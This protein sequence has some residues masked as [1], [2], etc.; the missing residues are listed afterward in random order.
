MGP[1]IGGLLGGAGVG[2]VGQIIDGVKG[3][4]GS[5]VEL[6]GVYEQYNVVLK[7]AMGSQAMANQTM[8]MIQDI[9]ATTPFQVNDLTD[10]YVKL[11]NRGIKLTAA[12]ITNLGDVAATLGKPFGQL[13]DAIV[14]VTS[15]KRWQT[16]GIKQELFK[17][18]DGAEKMRLSFRGMTKEVDRTVLGAKEAIKAFGE[19][20]NIAGQMANI[21]ATTAGKLSNLSDAWERVKVNIGANTPAISS[22]LVSFINMNNTI[23][24]YIG[25]PLSSKLEG[26]KSAVNN[27]YE[28][29]TDL[30]NVAD[31]R[32]EAV[33]TLIQKYPDYFGHL[34]LEKSKQEDVTKA[35]DN[36]NKTLQTK[37]DLQRLN[38]QTSLIKKEETEALQR[39]VLFK[40]LV[41]YAKEIKQ[42]Q[43][44]IKLNEKADVNV[45]KAQQN[46]KDAKDK[47]KGIIAEYDAVRSN[48]GFGGSMG[49]G[50]SLNTFNI[51]QL[52]N[53]LQKNYD[54]NNFTY[55]VLSRKTANFEKEVAGKQESLDT[56]ANIDEILRKQQQYITNKEKV[57]FISE[58]EFKFINPLNNTI[59]EKNYSKYQDKVA[60]ILG[61]ANQREA[62][63]GNT[64]LADVSGGK[65]QLELQMQ[66]E[67]QQWKMERDK[68]KNVREQASQDLSTSR[69]IKQINFKVDTI[70]GVNIENNNQPINPAKLGEAVK[71]VLVNTVADISTNKAF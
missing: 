52:I 30:N 46:I 5:I 14:A 62:E 58:E 6:T 23:N 17:G 34:D 9:A 71:T 69:N 67:K 20:V 12:E 65:S 26:E 33:K 55:E 38:E 36:Y 47:A 49:M 1:I 35:L 27:L 60:K 13:N 40:Q 31:V 10:S 59:D 66:Y 39:T 50:V 21:S 29:Y 54:E 57:K 25:I 41:E 37:I 53:R 24:D 2:S 48:L 64:N 11:A 61:D 70:N 45:K 22:L 8:Q 56:E 15:K 42:I 16:L 3:L 7:K 19:N 63:R 43:K 68:A 44:D 18:A 32:L 28:I 4:A 51:D